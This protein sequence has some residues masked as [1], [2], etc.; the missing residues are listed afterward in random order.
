MSLVG[1]ETISLLFKVP[2]QKCGQNKFLGLLCDTQQGCNWISKVS[3]AKILS[4]KRSWNFS[5]NDAK[6]TL[7]NK[8][9]M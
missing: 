5:A 8:I 6:N 1:S 4:M 2:K 7:K 3:H 9:C